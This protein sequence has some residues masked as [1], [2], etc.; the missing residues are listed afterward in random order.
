MQSETN[1]CLLPY[2]KPWQENAGKNRFELNSGLMLL[3]LKA[4]WRKQCHETEAIVAR[5]ITTLIE[6][7]MFSG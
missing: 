1:C 4:K 2:L 6:Q 5:K 7:G 3:R